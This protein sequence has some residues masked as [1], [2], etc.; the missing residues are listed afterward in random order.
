MIIDG[1]DYDEVLL[2]FHCELKRLVAIKLKI[3]KFQ[4]KDKGQIER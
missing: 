4:A 1:D 3:G 2:F